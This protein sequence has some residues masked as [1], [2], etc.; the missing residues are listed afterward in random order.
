MSK[1]VRTNSNACPW[2]V[3]SHLFNDGQ[4][5]G[6]IW[7]GT[8]WE[9]IKE[10]FPL[11]CGDTHK[12]GS[13]GGEFEHALKGKEMPAHDHSCNILASGWS[14]WGDDS[15][16]S[17]EYSLTGWANPRDFGGDTSHTAHVLMGITSTSG[18]S[19]AHNNTPPPITRCTGG[20]ARPECERGVI[21]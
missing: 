18:N 17:I 13:M 19:E 20:I 16:W 15:K 5:P 21:A 1:S 14:G 4:N 6:E 10:R 7:A 9:Q 11:G 8:V 3:G 12:A 2:P